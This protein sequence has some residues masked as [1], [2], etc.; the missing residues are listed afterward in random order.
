MSD[1]GR[2][3]REWRLYVRD[4]IEFCGV[5]L[6]YAAGLDRAAFLAERRTYDATLRNLQ[7]IGEA[8]THVP[9]AV[10]SLHPTIPWRKIIGMRNRLVHDYLGIDDDAIWQ[11][12]EV[13]VPDLLPK[14]R[15]LLDAEEGGAA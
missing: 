4:M 7:L 10:S 9:E 5:I 13:D 12:V 1:G 8:A 11:A 14:L 6:D 15:S 3:R 2:A